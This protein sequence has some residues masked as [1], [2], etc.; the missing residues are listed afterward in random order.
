[1]V[2][3]GAGGLAAGGGAQHLIT[4]GL[5]G[6]GGHVQGGGLA[7]A[8]YADDD[9][10]RSTRAADLLHRPPLALAELAA[11]L[12]LLRRGDLSDQIVGDDLG[13]SAGEAF[14][15]VRDGVLGGEHGGGG[16][17]LVTGT[18]DADERHHQLRGEDPIDHPV[19]LGGVMPVEP[20]GDLGHQ[21]GPV[22]HLPAGQKLAL[23]IQQLCCQPVDL[24]VGQ[25]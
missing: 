4:G 8:G 22:E 25:R 2:A 15:R 16:I 11:E 24:D 3:E 12:G 9:I 19:Q 14:Q 17:R 21:P 18:G 5:Q 7:R 20:R 6:P 1:L 13:P 10:D 23:G